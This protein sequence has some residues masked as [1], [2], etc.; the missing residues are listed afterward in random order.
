[1]IS[2]CGTGYYACFDLAML[3][4]LGYHNIGMYDGSLQEWHIHTELPVEID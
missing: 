3:E 1:V 4:L 2:Y